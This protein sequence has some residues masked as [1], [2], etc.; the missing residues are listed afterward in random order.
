MVRID[1]DGLA[2]ERWASVAWAPIDGP[3]GRTLYAVTTVEDVTELKRSEFA[4]QLL[5]R[6]GELL[7][8]SI[9]YRET[10]QAVV[11]L[12]VPEFADWCSVNIPDRDGLVERV[13][14]AHTDPERIAPWS[15]ICAS[16]TRSAS[17]T[18]ARSPR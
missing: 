10:L 1:S 14:I 13:A 5:G 9:D 8:S 3:D 16:G 12:A 15:R 4:Q 18:G 6:T 7:A 17:T 11:R 2:G